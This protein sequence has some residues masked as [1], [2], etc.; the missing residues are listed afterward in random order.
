M[1]HVA[2]ILSQ[3]LGSAR[4]GGEASAS[5]RGLEILNSRF[6]TQAII[7]EIDKELEKAEVYFALAR[8]SGQ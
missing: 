5:I 2:N 6:P 3:A 4:S 1:V 8:K 7:E